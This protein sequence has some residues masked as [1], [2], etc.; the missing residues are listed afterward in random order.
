MAKLATSLT[1]PKEGE[2]I[3]RIMHRYLL[4]KIVPHLVTVNATEKASQQLNHED[5]EDWRADS[6]AF[7]QD[8]ISPEDEKAE[9]Q[10]QADKRRIFYTR[11]MQANVDLLKPTQEWN[12]QLRE[13]ATGQRR[14]KTA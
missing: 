6:I 11:Y 9:K 8:L 3:A 14:H 5:K 12:K 7:F 4:P 2:A 1:L 13:N 10:L